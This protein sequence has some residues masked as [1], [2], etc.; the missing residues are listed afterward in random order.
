M[1]LYRWDSVERRFT[2]TSVENDMPYDERV[3]VKQL[4][5]GKGQHIP[6][7]VASGELFIRVLEGAWR[8]RIA[9]SHLT[10]RYNEAVI[11]PSG[12]S[13]SVEAIEDSYAVQ[14]INARDSAA[15]DSLWAV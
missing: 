14:M 9:E 15:R 5:V 8:L 11:I 12:F 1:T 4:R 3:Q 2:S 7:E 6:A 10:V 13:H